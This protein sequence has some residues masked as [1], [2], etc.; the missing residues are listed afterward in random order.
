MLR[1]L[2][3]LL[4]ALVAGVALSCGGHSSGDS[5]GGDH[6]DEID[7]DASSSGHA[8]VGPIYTESLRLTPGEYRS[9]ATSDRQKQDAGFEAMAADQTKP[10]F[11]G[12]VNGI[13]LYQYGN[14]DPTVRKVVC[15]GGKY[16]RH[17]EVANLS[18]GYLPPGTF[19]MTPQAAAICD[20][21]SVAG[22]GQ[23]L[24][25]M[26]S[27]FD[28]WYWAGE[29]ALAH[30]ASSDRISGGSVNGREAVFIRPVTESG[31]DRSYVAWSTE[32]G[33]IVLD[34]WMMPFEEI[35]RIAEGVECGSC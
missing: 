32:N 29:R 12:A 24:S 21:G 2:T 1:L 5:D 35:L 4:A 18:Y 15:D 30:D 20:S 34:A 11:E 33:M 7:R 8:G 10:R 9:P 16:A 19:A 23:Q 25:T 22:F 6:V 27:S 14:D 31:F 17:E 3:L 28:I 26:T 13:R